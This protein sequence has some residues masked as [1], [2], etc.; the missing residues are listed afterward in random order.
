MW[1]PACPNLYSVMFIDYYNIPV[2]K[3]S[4]DKVTITEQ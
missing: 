3:E 4:L 1:C 2:I